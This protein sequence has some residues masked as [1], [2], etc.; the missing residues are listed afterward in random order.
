MS[1]LGLADDLD[2]GTANAE[3]TPDTREVTTQEVT[4]TAVV[5]PGEKPEGI[6]D[7]FW[8]ATDKK[9]NEAALLEGYKSKD[10]QAL[11]MR[12]IIS[13]G[14]Q[15]VPENV[16][17]YKLELDQNIAQF[18][19][20]GDPA[21]EVA[22]NA[23][24]EAGL[25]VDQFNK[26]IGKYLG[27]L[28]EKQMLELPEPELTPEQIAAEN[29]KFYDAEMEKLGDSGK[30]NFEEFNTIMKEGLARGSFTDDDKEIYKDIM[31]SA[32]HVRFMKK[33]STMLTSRPST[34]L[35]IPN[36]NVIES[37]QLT[38]EELA[39]MGADPRMHSDP[40]F[41]AKRDA[42]YRALE[43]QGRLQCYCV[44]ANLMII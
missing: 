22:R 26:F 32:D 16:E 41:R 23:A 20:V 29:K 30:K 37:G 13:K 6:P 19:P 40:A 35:G 43:A 42:G 8:N 3:P 27:G 24:L 18:A 11:D 38:R 4:R 34:S 14:A 7:E 5:N 2:L 12:K 9:I 28:N 25:S 15:N 21:I 10:K 44:I 36:N 33:M 31:R 17:G 39:A 1:D